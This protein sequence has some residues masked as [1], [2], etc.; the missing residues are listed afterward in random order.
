MAQRYI[1]VPYA[2]NTAS[3]KHFLRD[4]FVSRSPQPMQFLL[5]SSCGIS[6]IFLPHISHKVIVCLCKNLKRRWF[7]SLFSSFSFLLFV[8]VHSRH[9]WHIG[10]LFWLSFLLFL[11]VLIPMLSLMLVFSCARIC[12][13]FHAITFWVDRFN[14]LACLISSF[15]FR[16]LYVSRGLEMRRLYHLIIIRLVSCVEP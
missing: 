11:C 15:S 7:S 13:V 2:V 1:R 8:P 14:Y 5:R 4:H 12:F 6:F 9:H 3:L 16:I 10:R